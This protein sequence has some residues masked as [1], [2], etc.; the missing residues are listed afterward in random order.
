MASLRSSRMSVANDSRSRVTEI[1]LAACS[2]HFMS[3]ANLA[4]VTSFAELYNN[5]VCME[6]EQQIFHVSRESGARNFFRGSIQQ[7]YGSIPALW[8]R[9]FAYIPAT[10]RGATEL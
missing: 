8:P 10:T 4:P 9:S 3:R 7:P 1:A 6:A 5:Y 2:R